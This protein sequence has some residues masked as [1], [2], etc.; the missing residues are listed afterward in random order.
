MHIG[1]PVARADPRLILTH[2]SFFLR[3]SEP[4]DLWVTTAIFHATARMASMH[5]G[6][7]W[8]LAE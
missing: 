1:P 7:R 3:R 6:E 2:L 5:V 4:M 8:G